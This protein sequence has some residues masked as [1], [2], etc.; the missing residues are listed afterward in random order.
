MSAVGATAVA[1]LPWL[2]E[3]RRM[4]GGLVVEEV[5][6]NDLDWILAAAAAAAAD[7]ATGPENLT[8]EALV[9]AGSGGN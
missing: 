1:T 4:D 3:G 6:L 8:L 2:E 7:G 5:D 9:L